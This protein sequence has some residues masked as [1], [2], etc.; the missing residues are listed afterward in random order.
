MY[1]YKLCNSPHNK[2]IAMSI[3]RKYTY[4]QVT[5]NQQNN[6]NVLVLSFI[7]DYIVL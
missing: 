2:H 3:I 7:I 6:K 4:H 5:H 1:P